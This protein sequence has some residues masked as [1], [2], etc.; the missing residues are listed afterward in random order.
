MKC[1]CANGTRGTK[2]SNFMNCPFLK[3][4]INIKQNKLCMRNVHLWIEWWAWNKVIETWRVNVWKK[5]W[6]WD[7]RWNN[8]NM[9]CPHVNGTMGAYWSVY[10]WTQG[11]TI[12][13]TIETWKFQVSMKQG[14]PNEAN[15]DKRS[16]GMCEW[17]NGHLLKVLETWHILVWTKRWAL[18]ETIE[19]W[20]HICII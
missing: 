14:G 9:K 7:T 19:T 16:L 5:Q 15:L 20:W 18:S 17:N 6:N 8:W 2:Q 4:E 1:L 3:R 10:M 13:E 12:N 11:W